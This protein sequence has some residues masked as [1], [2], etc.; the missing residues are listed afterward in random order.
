[1]AVGLLSEGE[2]IFLFVYAADEQSKA[3]YWNDTENA[4]AP[5][6]RGDAFIHSWLTS[7]CL[8]GRQHGSYTWYMTFSYCFG[9]FLHSRQKA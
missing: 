2:V 7:R 3:L 4:K 5:K 1:M 9:I 8:Q 6:A